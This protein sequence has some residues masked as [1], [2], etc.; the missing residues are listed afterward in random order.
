MNTAHVSVSLLCKHAVDFTA[1]MGS[2]APAYCTQMVS[3]HIQI[4]CHE[5]APQASR[6]L[7]GHVQILG[8]AKEPAIIQAHLK[9]LFSGI[10]SVEFS[11]KK[12]A[13]TAGLSM[14]GERVQLSAPVALDNQVEAWLARLS[15]A[16]QATLQVCNAAHLIGTE[17]VHDVAE[18]ATC[19]NCSHRQGL[20]SG[21][22]FG[23]YTCAA[24]PYSSM[25]AYNI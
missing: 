20:I 13:I 4:S 18:Q 11:D 8:Q 6:Q 14:E 10:H 24:S 16:M 2:C 12:D 1:H 23:P 25:Q 22:S 5:K 19:N 7:C 21:Q 3:E 9:K 15:T 17:S